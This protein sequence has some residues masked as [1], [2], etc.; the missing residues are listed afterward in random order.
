MRLTSEATGKEGCTSTAVYSCGMHLNSSMSVPCTPRIW[1]S[2]TKRFTLL[3]PRA[4]SRGM[5]W[6]TCRTEQG[7]LGFALSA[8]CAYTI[9]QG[10]LEV[11]SHHDASCHNRGQAAT[12]GKYSLTSISVL[13]IEL[14]G[15]MTGTVHQPFW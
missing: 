7:V 14:C 11:G 4:T 15:D 5:A 6:S 13:G 10:S 1:C 9:G 8:V 12:T 2:R 3:R